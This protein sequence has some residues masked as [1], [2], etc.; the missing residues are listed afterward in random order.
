M[1]WAWDDK[2]PAEPL[3]VEI[4]EHDT[5]K[6]VQTVVANIFRIDLRKYSKGEA[7]KR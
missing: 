1:G 2:R 3:V 4:Y 7:E 6:V 5:G